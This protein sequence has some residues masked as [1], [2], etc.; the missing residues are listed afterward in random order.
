MKKL[1]FL[2]LIALL[3]FG[4]SKDASLAGKSNTVDM[5]GLNGPGP[6]EWGYVYVA[7]NYMVDTWAFTND[8]YIEY[9]DENGNAQSV[10]WTTTIEANV[11]KGT[12][13]TLHIDIRLANGGSDKIYCAVRRENSGVYDILR[14]FTGTGPLSGTVL[15]VPINDANDYIGLW[16]SLEDFSGGELGR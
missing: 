11:K 8:S 14:N 16:A 5:A 6:T 15:T 2:P 10:P 1:L 7:F 3:C 4:C 13:I 12:T 9:T